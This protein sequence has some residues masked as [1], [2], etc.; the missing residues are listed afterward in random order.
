M[1]RRQKAWPGYGQTPQWSAARRGVLRTDTGLTNAGRQMY[2]YDAV[3]SDITLVAGTKYWLGISNT[4]GG[5]GSSGWAWVQSA[6]TGSARQYNS[7]TSAW[8]NS[9]NKSLAFNLTNNIVPEPATVVLSAVGAL[10][11]LIA[12]RRRLG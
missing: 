2:S 1:A 11:L 3:V 5:A 6:I 8:G 10:G 4:S 12:G 7:S 9:T